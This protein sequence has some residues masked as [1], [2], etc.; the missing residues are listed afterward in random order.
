MAWKKLST[1]LLL[2][3]AGIFLASEIFAKSDSHKGNPVNKYK[4]PFYEVF[5]INTSESDTD[6]TII[7]SKN[8][9]ASINKNHE[10]Q[11]QS[12]YYTY[13]IGKGKIFLKGACIIEFDGK[14]WRKH[15]RVPEDIE[16]TLTDSRR[17]EYVM[18][19]TGNI[20]GV[21]YLVTYPDKS[22]H[23][24]I[25]YEGDWLIRFC[26]A[27]F[28]ANPQN[29]WK[30][31][32]PDGVKVVDIEGDQKTTF[33]HGDIIIGRPDEKN[34]D[35]IA[36]DYIKGRKLYVEKSGIENLGSK[37]AV[38]MYLWENAKSVINFSKWNSSL[39][40]DE[41][42]EDTAGWLNGWRAGRM[43]F[44]I[45]FA[46]L[47]A[48]AVLYVLNKTDY[49]PKFFF[50]D[51]LYDVTLGVLIALTV[52]EVWYIISLQRDA[53]WIVFDV[54]ILGFF[55]FPVLAALLVLQLLLILTTEVNLVAYNNTYSW[56]PKKIEY[57]IGFLAMGTATGMMVSG[58][59][60]TGL[61]GYALLVAAGLPTTINYVR[62]SDGNC[63]MLPF[64]LLCYPVIYLLFLVYIVLL[65]AG[66]IASI[67]APYDPS[68]RTVT[69][70]NGNLVNLSKSANGRLMGNDGRE[71]HEIP[72]SGFMPEHPDENEG[73]YN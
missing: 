73:P 8:G 57:I 70:A 32:A 64:M 60:L 66:V 61:G 38:D 39:R 30:V 43:S 41:R 19:G 20:S 6:F 14:T 44:W 26:T 58:N 25:S 47:V 51:T 49:D 33:G 46:L 52:V 35:Y 65:A 3:F 12:S 53:L 59:L 5:N 72:G 15:P 29:V 56:F 23:M 9:H 54:G 27:G 7:F 67:E 50:P 62:H 36:I 42:D 31:T 40:F 10:G 45:L 24:H 55:T 1:L 13:T 2:S 68:V 22:V 16:M 37:N 28:L 11:R 21:T 48:A 17:P 34:G 63:S 71:Y 4:K 18:T 69:D